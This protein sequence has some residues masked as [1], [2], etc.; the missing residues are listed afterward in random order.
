MSEENNNFEE[1]VENKEEVQL[2][3]EL[4]EDSVV[5]DEFKEPQ[6]VSFLNILASVVV[7]QAIIFLVSGILLLLTGFIL[8]NVF[9]SYITRVFDMY[10][11]IYVIVNI[12]YTLIMSASKKKGTFGN[13]VAGL[14]LTKI[15]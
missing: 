11:V 7:D 2:T 5:R 15:K 9:Y 12:L 10:L 14:K 6:K 4:H 1:K 13:G 8:K 3:E